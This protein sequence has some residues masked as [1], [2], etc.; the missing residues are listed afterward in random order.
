MLALEIDD[1]L[2]D[3]E[4]W[5]RSLAR[6]R[7][8]DSAKE[9][10]A[11]ATAPF[12]SDGKRL[13]PDFP[14]APF[15]PLFV[16]QSYGYGWRVDSPEILKLPSRFEPQTGDV[17]GTWLAPPSPGWTISTIAGDDAQD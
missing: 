3:L 2:R 4:D 14:D 9:P 8:L 11:G 12:M 15:A 17:I 7:G 16:L 13:T 1:E 10:I 5:S 6:K